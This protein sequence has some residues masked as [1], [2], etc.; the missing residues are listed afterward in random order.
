MT[1]T[2]IDEIWERWKDG[3]PRWAKPD[4]DYLL[5]RLEETERVLAANRARIEELEREKFQP[6]VG[7]TGITNRDTFISHGGPI[8]DDEKIARS[9]A[10]GLA[11][12]YGTPQP[13]EWTDHE[14]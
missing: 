10:L 11:G 8:S 9:R 6:V 5:A 7:D 2:R 12:R 13:S 1:D 14:S 3:V 4:V